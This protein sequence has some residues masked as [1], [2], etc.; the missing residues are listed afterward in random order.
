MKI[1][2]RTMENI[3]GKIIGIL[4]VILTPFSTI[5]PIATDIKKAID[6][7]VNTLVVAIPIESDNDTYLKSV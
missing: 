2:F 3:G 7:K 6:E 1:V 5:S 4:D